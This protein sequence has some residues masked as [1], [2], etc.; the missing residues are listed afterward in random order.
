[1]S[2]PQDTFAVP[3]GPVECEVE[4]KKSRFIAWL[5][6][7]DSRAA[8]LAVVAEAKRR[9]PDARHHCYGWLIGNPANGQGAMQDDGEPAGTAGKPIFNVIAHK[10]V[11][12]VLVVVTRY[13]GGIKLGA[14]GLI[15]AYAGAAE[16]VLSQMQVIEQLPEI[17]VT[18]TF[19]FSQEQP[20]RHWCQQENARI[21]Q[22]DYGHCVTAQVTLLAACEDA[23]RAF[24]GARH[25]NIASTDAA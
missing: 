21:E 8:A 7:V 9:Y 6:P 18:L 14:G 23:L 25:I 11:G 3:A 12:N 10:G 4:V 13:F 16:A 5:R 17:A 1:M 2:A 19:D 15:R 24:C 22:I 20:L